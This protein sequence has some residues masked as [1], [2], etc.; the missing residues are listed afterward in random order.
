MG[1]IYLN[2]EVEWGGRSSPC[3]FVI[4]LIQSSWS[5]FK[6]IVFKEYTITSKS[7]SVFLFASC[8]INFLGDFTSHSIWQLIF[9]KRRRKKTLTT[10]YLRQK[11]N[12]KGDSN[13]S[14]GYTVVGNHNKFEYMLNIFY[15]K[16]KSFSVRK[17]QYI[18]NMRSVESV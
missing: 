10:I 3:V 13:G 4:S 17:V 12:A 15:F 14:Y 1:S 2:V 7:I 5:A 18:E 6:L 11:H 9:K 16:I 8:N